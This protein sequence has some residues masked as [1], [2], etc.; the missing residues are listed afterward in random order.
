[1]TEYTPLILS[2]DDDEHLLALIDY[3]VQGWGYRHLGVN[4]IERMWQ[5]LEE[6]TPN[7]I[8]LDLQLGGDDG[9]AVIG[10]LKDHL[11]DVP[12]IIITGYGTV[13]AAVGCLKKGAYDFATKPLDFG[14]LEVEVEKAIEH[15]RLMVKIKVLEATDCENDFHGMVGQ[16]DI[17]QRVYRRVEVVAPTDAAVLIL[18]ETGVGKEL[19]ARAIHRCSSRA[20]GPFVPVNAP[21]IPRELIE[22]ALFGHEKGAF[23]GAHQRH[24]GFCEQADGGTLFLDEICEMDYNIQAKLLRFLQDHVVQ[25]VGARSRKTVDV[26]VVAATNRNPSLQIEKGKLRSDFYYRLS[27]IT[28][29]LPPLRQRGEDIGLLA[30]YFLDLARRKYGRQMESISPEA[31]GILQEYPWP[32]NV[33][34]LEHLIHQIVITNQGTELAADMLGSDILRTAST[35]TPEMSDGN[36]PIKTITSINEMEQNLIREA[37][38]ITHGSIPAAAKQL[39]LSQTTLYRKIKKFGF[40]R[41]F[42]KNSQ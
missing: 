27:M 9:M 10:P 6:V 18:G 22:S 3:E 38:E 41:T 35:A 26:R 25:P 8:L 7:L 19:V 33:R 36:V 31:M 5:Q 34:Q 29:T 11:P 30:N 1:M 15:N 28:I 40:Q 17:M 24:M 23:T 20:A 13:D 21:A 2:V 14:R 32:G 37:L 39:G 16:S 4:S 42:A 12:I